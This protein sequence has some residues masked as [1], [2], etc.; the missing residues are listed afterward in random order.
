M[1]PWVYPLMAT[2]WFGLGLVLLIGTNPDGLPILTLPFGKPPVNA[3]W[4]VLL[5]A[6]WNAF[7]WFQ[8]INQKNRLR[9]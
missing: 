1:G 8:F 2:I 3:G 6:L 4:F 9:D 5:L 7:R